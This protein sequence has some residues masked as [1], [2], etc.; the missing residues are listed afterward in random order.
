MCMG[1]RRIL[2][3]R[4]DDLDLSDTIV[5]RVAEQGFGADW[6]VIARGRLRAFTLQDGERAEAEA[7]PPLASGRSL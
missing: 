5:R 6:R 4:P 3:G 1:V 7:E 2:T